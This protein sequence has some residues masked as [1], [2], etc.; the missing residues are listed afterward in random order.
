M[1]KLSASCKEE[2]K[3]SRIKYFREFR[4]ERLCIAVRDLS[5]EDERRFTGYQV[6]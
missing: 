1:G 6:D 3:S 2:G 5:I 4:S